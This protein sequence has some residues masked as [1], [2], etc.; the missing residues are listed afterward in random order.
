MMFCSPRK[1]FANV[2]SNLFEIYCSNLEND[3]GATVAFDIF[4]LAF[5]EFRTTL[6]FEGLGMRILLI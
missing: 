3:L 4:F 1:R 2:T 5:L 6:T